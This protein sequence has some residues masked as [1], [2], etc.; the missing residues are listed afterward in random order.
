MVLLINNVQNATFSSVGDAR[1][2][3][4]LDKLVAQ[5]TMI[6]TNPVLAS[7]MKQKVYF[8]NIISGVHTANMIR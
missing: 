2:T 3:T 4:Y 7:H 1:V 8:V 5:N 6:L